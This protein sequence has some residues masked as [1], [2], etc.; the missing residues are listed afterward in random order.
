SDSAQLLA[1]FL[2]LPGAG[3]V[4]EGSEER[5]RTMFIAV[6]DVLAYLARS[7]P[8][9]YVLEDLHYADPASMDLLVFVAARA[10]G[11]PIL[12][13]L[14]ERV[15]PGMPEIRPSRANFTQLVLQPLTEE[16]AARI[17]ETTVP[18]PE[19]LRDRI[20]ARA[21]GNPFFIEESIRSLIESGVVERNDAGGWRL[22]RVPAGPAAGLELP[23]TLH[24]VI[25]ARIDRLPALAKEAIQLASVVGVR[26]GDRVLRA[27]GGDRVA[28]AVDQLVAADLVIDA[29]PGERREGR[30]RF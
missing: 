28:D 17:V 19:D 10:T 24:A 26:F 20:V 2:H 6:F 29:A 4:V 14:A 27:S 23:A 5:Q 30:Y 12:F 8:I 9:L 25:A 11:I 15:G 7:R 3:E 22:A 16:E 1:Q 21:G 18:V 13:L